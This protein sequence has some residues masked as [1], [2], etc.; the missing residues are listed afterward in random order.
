NNPHPHPILNLDTA[1]AAIATLL[2][3]WSIPLALPHCPPAINTLQWT[4]HP[5][6]DALLCAYFATH[7][8]HPNQH[9]PTAH[10]LTAT[11]GILLASDTIKASTQLTNQPIPTWSN[12]ATFIATT[13]LALA[14]THPDILTI[15]HPHTTNTHR[16]LNRGI[17]AAFYLSAIPGV[18]SLAI[19]S[20]NTPDQ[21]LRTC[22]VTALLILL[23]I[24]FLRAMT[25][26]SATEADSRHRATHD[27]LTGL[28]NRSGLLHACTNALRR[29]R[30]NGHHTLMLFIDCDHFK[31]VNDTWGHSAGDVVLTTI[32]HRLRTTHPNDIT[33][34]NGGDE[35]ILI[36]PIPHPEHA[37][38]IAHT[39]LHSFDTPIEIAPGV[40]HN[41][42]PSIGVATATP[43]ENITPEELTARADIALYSAK[44]RGRARYAIFDDDLG[45]TARTRS[46]TLA[47]LRQAVTTNAIT[48]HFQPLMTGP[49]FT[50][51]L[52]WEALARWNDPTLGPIAPDIFIPLAEEIGLI[53]PLGAHVLR[54]A[55]REL[56]T[57][58]TLPGYEHT[59]V[60][61]NVSVIQLRRPDFVEKVLTTLHETNLP[62]TAL[63]LEVTESIPLI[64]GSIAHKTLVQLRAA[65]VAVSIDDF[66]TGYSSVTALLQTPA[67]TV[68]IDRSLT[69]RLDTTDDGIA[70]VSAA[71]EVVTSLGIPSVTAEGV[72]TAEQAHILT[73]LGCHHAQGWYFGRAEPPSNLIARHTHA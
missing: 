24:R 47:A 65:G 73:S 60:S 50:T 48:V 66:G 53:E 44:Q 27:P 11:F 51:I 30:I 70:Q 71:I 41:I 56:H 28:L 29:N 63:T 33:A 22:L 8:N 12:A 6:L 49:N 67:D 46:L 31:Y 5:T 26:L 69:A 55:C 2:I 42:T 45:A 9:T 62:P 37:K 13:T 57:L 68:K 10:W 4:I 58:R 15:T 35:F 1:A 3:L 39:T 36:T 16:T 52:G 14:F 19:H 18:A 20:N 25:K 40:F 34:R 64:E 23:F 21:I 54:T 59:I 7:A 43:T 32:A 72:E 17:N 38:T 61:V